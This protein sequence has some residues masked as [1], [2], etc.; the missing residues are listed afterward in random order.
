M[1][2]HAA[3]GLAWLVFGLTHSGLA[4]RTWFGRWSRLVYN[5]VAFGQFI[6]VGA[7]GAV[8]LGDRPGFALPPWAAWG[9]GAMHLAGWAV[10]LAAARFYDLGRLGGLTQLR[11]PD[12]PAD[13]ELRLDGPHAW[14]RHPLYAGAFLILWGA[15]LSPLGLATALWGSLYLLVGTACEEKRLARRYGAAYGAYRARVPAFIPWRGKPCSGGDA[16]VS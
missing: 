6:A 5:A 11:R 3:Y 2:A 8:L 4:G 9:L 1:M 12:A 7:V 14:V 16:G 10:L 15:A 13:E